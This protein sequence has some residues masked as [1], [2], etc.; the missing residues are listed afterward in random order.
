MNIPHELRKLRASL[1][2]ELIEIDEETTEKIEALHAIMARRRQVV[3]GI[4]G[5]TEELTK[6]EGDE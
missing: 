5:I 3:A 1:E 6:L 4:K 2:R